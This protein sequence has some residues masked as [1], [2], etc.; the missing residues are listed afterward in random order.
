MTRKIKTA[1]KKAPSLAEMLGLI[2]PVKKKQVK[3]KQV[4][5]KQVKKKQVKKKRAVKR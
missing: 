5:K 4:K 1:K 3:K 2:K